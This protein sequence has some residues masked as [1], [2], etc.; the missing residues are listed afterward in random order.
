MPNH[1]CAAVNLADDALGRR[2]RRAASRGRWPPA[3]ATADRP[4]DLRHAR[5][6][7]S[8][9]LPARD[10][11]RPRPRRLLGDDSATP[12]RPRDRRR[13]PAQRPRPDVTCDYPRTADAGRQGGRPAAGDAASP[14]E[15]D[16]RRSRPASATSRLTLDADDA[17]CTVNSF[18]SLAEQGYFDDTSCH[19]LRPDRRHL[20]AAVRRPDRHRL[21]RPGLLV[22]RRARPATRPTPPA[23]WRWPTPARTPTARSS[24]SCTATRRCPPPTPCSAPSTTPGVQ[25]VRD[26][27]AEGTARR[28]GRRRP[29]DDAVEIDRSPSTRRPSGR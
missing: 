8:P 11:R 18:V 29:P 15:V 12:A 3:A 17:P 21:R 13:P 24:S 5:S 10:R 16:R 26:V 6:A 2:R 9:C 23:P 28:D 7:P 25:V 27:A 14:G 19:R 4:Y 22:R 20:R 1:V